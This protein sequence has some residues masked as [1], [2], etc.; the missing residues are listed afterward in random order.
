MLAN[1]F[2]KKKWINAFLLKAT[3]ATRWRESFF[4]GDAAHAPS[5]DLTW[6]LCRCMGSAC[7]NTTQRAATANIV[8]RCTMTGPGRQQTAEQGLLTSAGVSIKSL[9]CRMHLSVNSFLSL[10]TQY[11]V[12]GDRSYTK[13]THIIGQRDSSHWK[14]LVRRATNRTEWSRMCCLFA[15]TLVGPKCCPWELDMIQTW[16]DT[17]ATKGYS[18]RLRS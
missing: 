3:G 14:L 4:L 18:V 15:W 11:K 12:V 7:A 13:Y 16:A 2:K 17:R 5:S 10:E 1:F 6:L 9:L 8:P